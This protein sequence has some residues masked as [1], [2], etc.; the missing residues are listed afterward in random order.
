MFNIFENNRGI[1]QGCTNNSKDS[2]MLSCGLH[3]S[4]KYFVKNA[5]VKKGTIKIAMPFGELK[6][7]ID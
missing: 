5:F 7:Q 1:K 3:F 6:E 2:C 4:F